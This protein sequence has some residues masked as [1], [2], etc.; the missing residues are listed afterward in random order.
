[1]TLSDI[2]R[3]SVQTSDACAG[4]SCEAWDQER[5]AEEKERAAREALQT[6]VAN[7]LQ[8]EKEQLEAAQRWGARARS[9]AS[10]RGRGS[11][12]RLGEETFQVY[13]GQRKRIFRRLRAL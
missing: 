3:Q 8:D 4:A 6:S 13:G 9:W 5:V 11:V 2:M 7:L 12:E 1:M 10:A